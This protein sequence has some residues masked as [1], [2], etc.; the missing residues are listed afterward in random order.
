MA[1]LAAGLAGSGGAGPRSLTVIA[2]AYNSG[3]AGSIA[4]SCNTIAPAGFYFAC[5]VAR[6]GFG[7]LN[8]PLGAPADCTDKLEVDLQSSFVRAA[9]WDKYRTNVTQCTSANVMV[10]CSPQCQGW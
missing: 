10:C 2:R 6:P 7:L 1:G 9:D 3:A 4:S 5:G 8:S